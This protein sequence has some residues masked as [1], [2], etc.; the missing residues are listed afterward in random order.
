VIQKIARYGLAIAAATAGVAVATAT[1]ALAAG[2]CNTT[3]P[4]V[5]P[6]IDYP[7]GSNAR[8]DF[9]LN[10]APDSSIAFYEVSMV[11]NGN[12][13][14]LSGRQ[15][16]T[17]TGRYCCWYQGVAGT[18]PKAKEAFTRVKIFRQDGVRH[19]TQDSPTIR[20]VA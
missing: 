20:F 19:L 14:P 8:A 10:R 6:C 3:N 1:P 16:L 18:S 13:I 5:G 12:E 15:K 17:T 11:V 7:G 4:T 9:Y 2:G